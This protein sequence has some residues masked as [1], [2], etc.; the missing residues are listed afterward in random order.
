MGVSFV[1]KGALDDRFAGNA[2]V[3]LRG[4]WGTKPGGGMFGAR[5]TRRHPKLVMVEFT[6]G[7]PDGTVVDLV[8]GFQRPDG[9]RLL[10]PVGVAIGPDGA[11]YFTSDAHL[12]GLFRLRPADKTP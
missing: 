6:G 3:A 11:L 12:Q 10:R 8:T 2:I 4:S 9:E 7:R 5:A 1:P